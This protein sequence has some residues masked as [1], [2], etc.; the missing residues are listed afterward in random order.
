LIGTRIRLRFDF[1]EEF[2]YLIEM[3][4]HLGLHL[5]AIYR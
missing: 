2:P 3:I 4:L 5:S 1:V